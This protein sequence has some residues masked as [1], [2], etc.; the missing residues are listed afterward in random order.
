MSNAISVEVQVATRAAPLPD[1]RRVTDCVRDTFRFVPRQSD[2]S[3][4]IVVR[5]VDEDEI[6]GLNSQFRQ[7]D[8][9]TNV[10]AFPSHDADLAELREEAGEIPLGDIVICAPVVLREAAEQGKNPDD[11]WAHLLI[12]GTLHL[13]GFDHTDD[14]DAA[15]MEALETRI[16]AARGI[17]DPYRDR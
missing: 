9:A 10:L 16:L 17:G 11:H 8:K 1:R 15:E 12:H 6:R 4:E 3:Y 5:I 14:Q 2:S 7:I 13:L